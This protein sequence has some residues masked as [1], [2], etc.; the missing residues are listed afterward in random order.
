MGAFG[1]GGGV[2]RGIK[3]CVIFWC[4]WC[5]GCLRCWDRVWCL[6]RFSPGFWEVL[7]VERVVRLRFRTVF[8]VG[9]LRLFGA[10]V[11]GLDWTVVEVTPVVSSSLSRRFLRILEGTFW[12]LF[13]VILL[14]G[15]VL[16]VVGG[17]MIVT[18]GRLVGCGGSCG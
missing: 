18:G 4:L 8:M 2:L 6:F 10:K 12:S 5:I 16:C 17:G 11:G 9:F 13:F 3:N 1:V 15:G 7:G 14:G